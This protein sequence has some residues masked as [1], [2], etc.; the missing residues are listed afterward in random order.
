MHIRPQNKNSRNTNFVDKMIS[1][2]FAIQASA[3][4]SH[5]NWVVT[6]ILEL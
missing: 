2:I 3:E 1:N 4:I 5:L 6:S